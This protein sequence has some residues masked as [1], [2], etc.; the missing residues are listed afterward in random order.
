[1]YNKKKKYFWNFSINMGNKNFGIIW[2]IFKTKLLMFV[3]QNQC[4]RILIGFQISFI[5]N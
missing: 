4:E 2:N 5:A 3:K 1:M